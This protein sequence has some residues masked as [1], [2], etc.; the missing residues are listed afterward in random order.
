VTAVPV[1]AADRAGLVTPP[2]V[3]PLAWAPWLLAVACGVTVAN[4]VYAQPLTGPIG[5]ALGLPAGARGLIVTLPQAGYGLSLLLIVPLAD[6]VENR[7]LVLTLLL[8]ELVCLVALSFAAQPVTFLSLAFLVGLTAAVVQILLPYVTYLVPEAERGRAVGTVVSGI[9]FGIMLARPLSSLVADLWSWRVMFRISAILMAALALILRLVL[10]RRRP[11]PGLTYRNLLRSMGGIFL[12]TELLRRRALYHACLF[13]A[14][15]AFWTAAPLWL[16]G[17][18][19]GLSQA[20]VAWIAL[21][22]VSGALAPPL[23]SRLVDRGLT[24]H[25]TVT[26]MLLVV[27]AFAVSMLARDGSPAAIGVVILAAIIL[28]AAVSANLVFGQRAVYALAAEQRSRLN[29][30]Y[31]ATFFSGGAIGSALS[32]WAYARFGWGAVALLGA[33]LPLLALAYLSTERRE[34]AV[35]RTTGH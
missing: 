12:N 30:L 17:R 14:F 27:A 3:A 33:G 31:M 26:A 32:G 29:G 23:A 35:N 8:L 21:A 18:Q 19:F 10:P 34:H 4:L 9:M 16:S 13:A 1:G 11:T 15:S 2:K 22:G 5:A 7:R 25:G 28:D 6:L 20:G 24:R